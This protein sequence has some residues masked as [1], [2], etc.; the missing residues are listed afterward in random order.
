MAG[1][2]GLAFVSVAGATNITHLLCVSRARFGTRDRTKV[3]LV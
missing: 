1:L 2:N 3:G